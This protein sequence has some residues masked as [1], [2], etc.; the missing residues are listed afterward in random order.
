MKELENFDYE[1][2]VEIDPENLDVEWLEQ[3]HK[4]R[5]ITKLQAY[6]KKKMDLAEEKMDLVKADIDRSI[7]ENPEKYGITTK[8]TETLITNTI[9]QQ[10]EYKDAHLE[11]LDVR[12]E[13]ECAKGAVIAF[14]QR[15]ASLENLV[16]L[17]GMSYFAGPKIPRNIKEEVE[18]YRAKRDQELNKR[19]GKTLKRRRTK[20]A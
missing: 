4:M 7:R 14:E 9:K 2:E 17:H 1:K 16:K 8:L 6:L 5:K 19:I 13:Y 11:Y 10:D 12:Y 20:H 3:P 18:N 15:K